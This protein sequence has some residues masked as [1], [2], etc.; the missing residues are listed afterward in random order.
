MRLK[1]EDVFRE[2][3]SNIYFFTLKKVKNSDIAKDIAQNV[4]V[5]IQDK[6]DSLRDVSKLR[7]WTLQITRNEINNFYNHSKKTKFDEYTIIPAETFTQN[8]VNRLCCFDRF[9]AELPPLQRSAVELVYFN[10]KKLSEAA[11]ELNINLSNIKARIRR[12]KS[13]LKSKLK[14]CCRFEE[15]KPLWT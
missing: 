14:N 5:K 9:V 2:H 15:T 7:Q 10:G 12:A 4:F 3:Y 13:N 11:D 1:T 8:T 6:M